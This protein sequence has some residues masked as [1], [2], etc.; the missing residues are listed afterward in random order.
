MDPAIINLIDFVNNN[1]KS[2]HEFKELA[3]E[4]GLDENVYFLAEYT[5]E[6][7]KV[8]QEIWNRWHTTNNFKVGDKV[9]VVPNHI[10]TM[11]TCIRATVTEVDSKRGYFL[12]AFESDLPGIYMFNIWDKDLEIRTSKKNK[13]TPKEFFIER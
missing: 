12:R 5:D 6:H 3:R 9:Y 10:T 2:R 8:M 11:K 4:R 1:K 7:I 13:L